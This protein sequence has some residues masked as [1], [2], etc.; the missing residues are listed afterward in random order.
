[1]FKRLLI[2]TLIF[3]LFSI[4]AVADTGKHL[5]LFSGDAV[6]FAQSVDKLGGE[7][8][9]SH[10]KTGFAVVSGLNETMAAKLGN[11]R[12]VRQVMPNQTFML[13]PGIANEGVLEAGDAIES[14]LDPAGAAFFG[15]QWHMRAIEAD[16]AWAAGRLGSPAVTVA[17]LDTGIAY[18]HA[19]LA[20]LVDLGRSVSFLPDDDALV[21][22]LFPGMHHVTDLHYHG[23]HVASTV[24]SNAYAAAGVTS[25]TTLMGVKVCSVF[26]GCPGDAIFQGVLHAVDNGADVINMSLGGIFD[27][28]MYPGYVSV[29]NKLFNYARSNGVTI[30]VSAGND[31][32]DLDH[33]GS[34]YKTYCS[35]P[36]T[37]CV[38]A[39]GPDYQEDRYGPWENIDAPAV[40]SNYG[41]SSV[42]VAAPGGNLAADP[43]GPGGQNSY[44]R[45]ACSNT[46]LVIPV[47][48]TG[49]YVVG[50]IGTS[51]ASPHVAGLAALMV[52]DYGRNPGKVKTAIQN[53]ADD[54]GQRGTDPHYGKGR[55]NVYNAVQ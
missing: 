35:T 41:R 38:A 36:A 3:S 39:T 37:I 25:Q 34:E 43:D 5:V 31:A 45:A 16:M 11:N 23:T 8:E 6:N 13:D 1:M 24:S 51:M 2:V 42:D 4:S 48:Q 40:Y 7:V 19:D 46:S 12:S 55:I 53:S 50:L 18:T 47:C 26:G 27:K 17:I 49:T 15:Q 28:A 22:A 30:V 32:H 33:D 52:E 44:V 54:L 10:A 20:G 21:D 9:F 29:I 14:P